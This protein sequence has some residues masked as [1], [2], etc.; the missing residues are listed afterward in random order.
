[1][2]AIWLILLCARSPAQEYRIYEP[3]PRLL[4][5]PRKL[6]L[7]QKERDRQSMRWLQFESVVNGAAELPEPGLAKALYARV[8]GQSAPCLEAVRWAQ[9]AP[10]DLRQKALVLDWCHDLLQEAQIQ[11]LASVLERELE[12]AEQ[13]RSMPAVRGRLLAAIALAEKRPNLASSHLQAILGQWW[14][15]AAVPALRTSFA[16]GNRSELFAAC[17]MLHAVQD[18][19]KI[20]L[21]QS[22]PDLFQDLPLALLLAYYP[23]PYPGPRGDVFLPASKGAGK[24]DPEQALAARAAGLCLVSYGGGSDQ[25]QFL[26]GFLMQDHYLMR[27]PRGAVYEFLWA[28]P[29]RPGLSYHHAPLYFHSRP[30]GALFAR[31]SWN[32]DATWLGYL[33]GELQVFDPDGL[34]I[35]T[36]Q[37]V[38]KPI[39]LGGAAVY[40]ARG[41]PPGKI[42]PPADIVFVVG[43]KP[44]TEYLIEMESGKR[45]TESADRAG[46]LAVNLEGGPRGWIRLR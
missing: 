35:V 36:A 20:D 39:Q 41:Q 1:M 24:P 43:L 14:E 46:I 32:Q 45:F 23:A 16:S 2:L 38:S 22:D 28:N 44:E 11:E 31:S 15:N 34:K 5:P 4:L 21:R 25:S 17:E 18:N 29:Y 6:A 30:L 10:P 37:P 8:T 19:L 40:V 7:L 42:Q 26:Q 12:T 9:Q 13:D 33:G 3:H 27:D